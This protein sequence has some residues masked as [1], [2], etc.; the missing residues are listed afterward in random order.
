MIILT[1]QEFKEIL[2]T[3][4]EFII[5]VKRTLLFFII[6]MVVTIYLRGANEAQSNIFL[7]NELKQEEY[8]SFIKQ[9]DLKDKKYKK[10]IIDDKK[11]QPTPKAQI[12]NVQAA[13]I[14]EIQ[15][16]GLE[17]KTVTANK[18]NNVVD[19]KSK[20]KNAAKPEDAVK[21]P[22]ADTTYDLSIEGKWSDIMSVFSSFSSKNFLVNVTNIKIDPLEKNS[23]NEIV[24]IEHVKAT[25]KYKLYAGGEN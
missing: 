23:Q 4:D 6:M 21:I 25:I 3:D 2:K 24:D 18:V 12:D 15:S 13:L 8:L 5:Y 19:T 14:E 22:I 9:Y 7:D 10:I 17:I 16:K 20:T 11:P 1:W